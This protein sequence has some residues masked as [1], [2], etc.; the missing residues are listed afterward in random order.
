MPSWSNSVPGGTR[1]KVRSS[2]AATGE[3]GASSRASPSGELSAM[4][5]TLR[6]ATFVGQTRTSPCPHGRKTPS[7]I[8]SRANVQL[9]G[10]SEPMWKVTCTAY[11]SSVRY[12]SLAGTG[13]LR[14]GDSTS[15]ISSS[16][17]T[18]FCMSPTSFPRRGGPWGGLCRRGL[19]LEES[20]CLTHHY[21]AS[22]NPV[23]I[24]RTPGADRPVAVRTP[25]EAVRRTAGDGADPP[26]R[27]VW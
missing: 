18:T 5:S 26:G 17:S 4:H 3:E 1:R 25:E 9:T 8:S 23:Q 14:S 10:A 2:Q 15:C 11:G 24:S 20:A 13:M 27:A 19:H 12:V 7:T 6:P 22:H 16:R 21:A